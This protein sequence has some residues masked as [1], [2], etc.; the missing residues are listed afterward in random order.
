M[1][2]EALWGKTC[3]LLRKE[4][5]VHVYITF[6]EGNLAPIRLAGDTLYLSI[7]MEPMVVMMRTKYCGIID[8]CLSEAAGLPMH[9]VI[10]TKEDR[11][12]E[13]EQKARPVRK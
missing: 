1:E 7:S 8:R 4:M 2:M 6:I 9:S 10:Q 12:K 3:E 5:A 13:E 11:R